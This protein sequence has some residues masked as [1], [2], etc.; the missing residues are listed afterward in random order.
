[1]HQRHPNS[2]SRANLMLASVKLD[3]S[4]FGE[5]PYKFLCIHCPLSCMVTNFWYHLGY[6]RELPSITW[7]FSYQELAYLRKECLQH[8][9][10]KEGRKENLKDVITDNTE[11]S[12]SQNNWAKNSFSVNSWD[13]ETQVLICKLTENSPLSVP[14]T[15][16]H[17]CEWSCAN[18]SQ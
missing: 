6:T 7:Q 15:L 11:E 16:F 2:F 4:Q 8:W 10:R 14:S 12:L 5:K 3:V 9:V 17:C 13:F 18:Q 1:M